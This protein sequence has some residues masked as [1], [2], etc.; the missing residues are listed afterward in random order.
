MY[1]EKMWSNVSKQTFPVYFDTDL[2]VYDK[3]MMIVPSLSIVRTSAVYQSNGIRCFEEE[4]PEA[5]INP[6]ED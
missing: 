1:T 4:V 6:Q 2:F 3:W 5:P